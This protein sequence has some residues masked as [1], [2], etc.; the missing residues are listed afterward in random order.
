MSDQITLQA[1]STRVT[2]TRTSKRLRREGQIPG[3]VYGLGGEPTIVAVGYSD[4]RQAMSTDA[5]LNALLQLN[6]DGTVEECIVKDLQRHPVRDEVIHVDFLRVDPNQEV[7]VDVPLS[8]VGEA[9]EVEQASGMVDQNMFT[10]EILAKPAAIPNELEVDI[11]AMAIG[12]SIRVG[13]LALP[14]GVRTEVDPEDAIAVAAVTRSTLDAIAAEEAAELEG[15]E[16]EAAPGDEAGG[17]AGGDS[18]GE[19]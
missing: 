2:G 12:D 15:E 14:E 19:G 4:L 7:S 5:G 17:D 3:V 10:L 16:G 11:S 13:D 1:D 18:D 6:V 9:R 8:F